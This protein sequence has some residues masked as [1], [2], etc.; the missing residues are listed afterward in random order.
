[1][2][3]VFHPNIPGY[4][5]PGYFGEQIY[6]ADYTILPSKLGI[7]KQSVFQDETMLTLDG[8]HF[9]TIFEVGRSY[10]EIYN[11]QHPQVDDNDIEWTPDVDVAYRWMVACV[12]IFNFKSGRYRSAAEMGDLKF[13]CMRSG[14]YPFDQ[15]VKE[16]SQNVAKT[17]I[18]DLAIPRPPVGEYYGPEFAREDDN[19]KSSKA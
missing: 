17:L 7:S 2:G 13:S 6:T 19:N 1:M 18:L 8:C 12:D 5:G 4:F 3:K 14:S 10:D 11:S 9:D 16:R 15:A